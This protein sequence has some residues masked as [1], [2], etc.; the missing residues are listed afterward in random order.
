MSWGRCQVRWEKFIRKISWHSIAERNA[1]QFTLLKSVSAAKDFMLIALNLMSLNF[2]VSVIEKIINRVAS[3]IHNELLWR[4]GTK[5]FLCRLYIHHH[6]RWKFISIGD[7]WGWWA[8][9]LLSNELISSVEAATQILF[10]DRVL[11]RCLFLSA[12]FLVFDIAISCWALTATKEA[13]IILIS[14]YNTFSTRLR[15]DTETKC[16]SDRK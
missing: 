9:K 13:D 3:Q 2:R 4:I 5:I 10:Y 11:F 15:I 16:F 8:I 7:G 1:E 6:K 12:R 14:F